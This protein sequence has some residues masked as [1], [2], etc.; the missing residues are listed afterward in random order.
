MKKL[1]LM[2]ALG[3]IVL[4]ACGS[5]GS[6]Q[7]AAT[8]DNSEVTVGQVE[9]LIQSEESTIAKEQF[10]QFL[11]FQIQWLIINAA[12]EADYG[13]TT[14]DEEVETEAQRIFEEASADGQSREDFLAER[15]ISDKFLENI[16]RQALLDNQIRDV[17][18]EDVEDPTA[19][20]LESELNAAKA[21][22]TTA[23]VSHILVATEDEASD[24]FDRLESGEEFGVL[25]QEVS[26]DT[27]SGENN[28]IL[29][30][31]TLDQYVEPFRDAALVA[32]VG[33]VYDP[34]VESQ[35]GW[36][37]LLVTD[38]QDADPAQL[39]D[40]EQLVNAVRDA[41]VLSAL[42]QWFLGAVNDADV[43]VEEEFGTWQAVPS[44]QVV[45]PTS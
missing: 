25:A 36:H 3:A 28:G 34:A 43:V 11:S 12:A 1:V 6:T 18:E 4:A 32:P 31:G 10:A 44:P 21:P 24:V 5:G 9:E 38:R 17:L 39:P 45:P 16:A 14:T 40:D 8:V 20:E 42:E 35:F 41:K 37:I 7:V 23:C 26:T 15:G 29:P 19:E 2:I 33:E 27:G 13:V 22:L 30:C